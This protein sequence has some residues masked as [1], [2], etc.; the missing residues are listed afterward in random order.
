MNP[1]TRMKHSLILLLT[2]AAVT[3]YHFRLRAQNISWDM[4]AA[5]G[6]Q[7]GTGTWGS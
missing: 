2:V 1:L 7:N 3:G 5:A 4:S 6:Y